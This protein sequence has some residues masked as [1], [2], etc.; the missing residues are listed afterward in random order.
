MTKCSPKCLLPCLVIAILLAG[1]TTAPAY[2]QYRPMPAPGAASAGQKGENYHVEISGHAWNPVPS[3]VVSSD[4]LGISG[5]QIDAQADL[6]IEQKRVY[7]IRVVLKPAAKHKFRFSYQLMEYTSTATLNATVYFKGR[8]YPVSALVGSD[9]QWKTYRMGY[10]YDF[11]SNN[12]GFFGVILEAK[13]TTAQIQIDSA[14]GNEFAKAQA[15]IPAIGAIARVY[16]APGFSVTGEYSIFKLPSSILKDVDAHYT[17]F[18]VYATYNLTNNIGA[19][20]GYRNIDVGVTV[21]NV[22]D[23]TVHGAAKLNGLYFGG[24]LRF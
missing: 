17:E 5:T 1:S 11:V 19:Q 18:D 4:G 24:V 6:G 7:D 10:E 3:F 15:P 12:A 16:L 8:E 22:K 20:V 21:D 23:S 2:A 9:L 13:A 14:V